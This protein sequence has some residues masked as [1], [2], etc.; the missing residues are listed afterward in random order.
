MLPQS[1]NRFNKKIKIDISVFN[2]V[3]DPDSF[4]VITW[5]GNTC[6]RENRMQREIIL[7]NVDNNKFIFTRGKKSTK[8]LV[9]EE[10]TI[11]YSMGTYFTYNGDFLINPKYDG[12]CI[13]KL[14]NIEIDPLKNYHTKGI[15]DHLKGTNFP[16]YYAE[17][18]MIYSGAGYYSVKN[19]DITVI[20]PGHVI[21]SYFYYLSTL[22]IYHLIYGTFEDGLDKKMYYT[23][24]DVPL[25]FYNSSIIR[26]REASE[27]CKYKLI[28]GGYESVARI[29]ADFYAS[30]NQ[31]WNIQKKAY[32][33]SKIPFDELVKLDVIGRRISK[34]KFLVFSIENF[35]FSDL[36]Q[37]TFLTEKFEMKDLSDHSTLNEEFDE[38]ENYIKH[39]EIT[40]HNPIHTDNPTNH[41][42]S[43]RDVFSND[44]R[45]RFYDIPENRKQEKKEQ[46]EQYSAEDKVFHSLNEISENIRNHNGKNNT[47]RANFF[48]N[49]TFDYIN[50]LFEAVDILKSQNIDC[51]Y[52]FID[53]APYKNTSY[54]P[55]KSDEIAPFIMVSI[56]YNDFNFCLIATNNTAGRMALLKC[57]EKYYRFEEEHDPLIEKSLLHMIKKFKGLAWD[58][59]KD[60]QELTKI[61]SANKGVSLH[62]QF[63]HNKLETSERTAE[64]LAL[65]IKKK[66]K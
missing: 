42:N 63:N 5:L 52:I 45:K 55:I 59:I 1:Q 8:V 64:S 9:P 36:G 14:E 53:P 4:W 12:Y 37:K 30:L 11:H 40:T 25:F 19:G 18:D 62:H 61:L 10:K 35:Q 20:I 32:I 51:K 7:T 46:K 43:V 21:L 17:D 6:W 39:I 13:E 26:Y 58:K 28:K 66:L 23:E 65:K 33:T 2:E 29:H 15:R 57:S 48:D 41:N 31:S 3:N 27:I 60:T 16:L 50:A 34:D 22:Q 38:P 56:Y 44:G 47:S 24:N 54:A 49:N